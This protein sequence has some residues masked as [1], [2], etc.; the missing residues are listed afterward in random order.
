M[1]DGS[2]VGSRHQLDGIDGQ[3]TGLETVLKDA[4]QGRIGMDGLAAAPQNYGVATLDAQGCGV[5]G[6][7]GARFV[8]EENDSEGHA[9]FLNFKT[10]GP[11]GAAS[12][13]AH[14]I[15][16]SSYFANSCC[17]A[18]QPG[19]SQPQAIDLR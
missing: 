7:I 18:A 4:V 16:Q 15:G 19:R 2:A 12:Y 11:N 13:L 10:I 14:R 6:D 3:A 5:Q 9:D 8:D 1:A 17:R